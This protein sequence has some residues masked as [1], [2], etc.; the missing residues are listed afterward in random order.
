M[1]TSLAFKEH[2]YYDLVALALCLRVEDDDAQWIEKVLSL[3]HPEDWPD[4]VDYT[5][6]VCRRK[7]ALVKKYRRVNDVT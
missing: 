2:V 5:S 3:G 4:G 7:R 1:A 6:Y